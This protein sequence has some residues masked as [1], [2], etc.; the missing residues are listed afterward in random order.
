MR[1][2]QVASIHLQFISLVSKALGVRPARSSSEQFLRPDSTADDSGIDKIQTA[3]LRCVEITE[4]EPATSTSGNSDA[5]HGT[6]GA[7][8]RTGQQP[9]ATRGQHT[10]TI[11]PPGV[12]PLEDELATPTCPGPKTRS[13][14]LV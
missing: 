7:V 4:D 1:R 13:L 3:L 9:N 12:A 14:R 10:L 6:T 8:T 5:L 2:L 11:A